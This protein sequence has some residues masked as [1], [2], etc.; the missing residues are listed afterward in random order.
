MSFVIVFFCVNILAKLIPLLRF[1]FQ[2]CFRKATCSTGTTENEA[3]VL[4]RR[5]T[6]FVKKASDI[7]GQDTNLVRR[8]PHSRTCENYAPINL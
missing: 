6:C 8:L 5:A 7:V 4:V 1:P 3:V 2:V